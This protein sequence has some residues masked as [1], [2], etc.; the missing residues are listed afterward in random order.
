MVQGHHGIPFATVK[1]KY[2]T[3]IS[4]YGPKYKTQPNIRGIGL[5][6]ALKFGITAGSFGVVGM[7]FA[8]QFFSDV[9]KVKTDICQKLPIIGD[10]FIKDIPPSDNPF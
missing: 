5:G 10:Y 3:Y 7:I 4:P 1:P 8:L 2:G 6:R 9:P